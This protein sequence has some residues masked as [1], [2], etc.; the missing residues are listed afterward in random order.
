MNDSYKELLVKKEQGM[1]DK[2][3]RV[4][5]VIPTI[6]FG[7]LTLLTGNVILFAVALAFG[8]LDYFVFQWTD[9]EFEYLYL[10][11]E[12]VVDKIMAQ[13]RR[14]RVGTY[15]LD[16]VEVLAPIN[17]YHL[18]NYKNRQIKAKDYSIGQALKPDKRYVM[19]VEGNVK[20]ILS[21]SEEMVKVMKNAAPRKIF[22]D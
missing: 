3:L 16:R 9:I 12:L 22:N 7:L 21:P 1:K 5:C 8:V 19:Y 10:D 13:T 15:S 6:F 2:L 18:D 14:K 11:R 4:V 20:I 17:S